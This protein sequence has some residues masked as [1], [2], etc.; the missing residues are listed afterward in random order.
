MRNAFLLSLFVALCNSVLAQQNDIPLQRDIYLDVERNA[1]CRN[2]RIHSGMK[3]LIRSRADLTNVMGHRPDKSRRYYWLTE[4]LFRRHL[5]QVRTNDVRID[6]DLLL[7]LQLGQD[8]RDVSGFADTTRFYQNTR[9]FRVSGDLG[10]RFSFESSFYEN[11]VIYPQYLWAYTRDRGVVPGQGRTKP[12]N[13]RAYDF[14]W[15]TGNISWSPRRSINVQLGQG[16]HFVGHGYRS[17]LLGDNGFTYPFLKVSYLGWQDRLQYTTIHGRLQMLQRLPEENITDTLFETSSESL[18]YWKPV[19]FHHLSVHLGPVELGLFEASVFK[20]LDSAGTRP[21]NALTL[22]PIIGLNTALNGFDGDHK[23]V[24]GID[25][26]VKITDKLNV[27]GQGVT[28]GPGRFGWQA[29]FRW[30]DL[31]GT[32]LHLQM[33]YNHAS[34]FL[35][36][37]RDR[38]MN[39][40]HTQEALA[41][42]YGAY[43]DEAVAIVDY[44]IKEKVLLQAKVNLATYH[45]NGPDSLGNNFGSD[46]LRNDLPALGAM[47]PL[48]RNL[49]YVDLSV[50]YLL[51]QMSNM[52]FTMGYWMRDLTPA[53]DHQNSGYLYAAFRMALFNRYYDL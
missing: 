49:T 30:F 4:V 6:A 52:R 40:S 50:S 12:F 35:Y 16:R 43:F 10:P 34:P 41:H 48:V 18:F 3:P 9:G 38:L 42:P 5:V 36:M 46:I 11:Q 28:D 33:E 23:Q 47:G 27:Y 14:A 20:A 37:Q 13:G 7:D 29:G 22:N 51:N 39:Y 2:A 19:S 53:P 25:L 24:V 44:R 31:F 17:M 8:F 26:C 32:D 1:A 21:F 45:L 15:A